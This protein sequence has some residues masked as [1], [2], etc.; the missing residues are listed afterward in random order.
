MWELPTRERT[1]GKELGTHLEMGRLWPGNWKTEG[2]T[3][4]RRLDHVR[5]AITRH[6]ILAEVFEG[7]GFD[8]RPKRGDVRDPDALF[9]TP[10]EATDRALTGMTR[11]I[12]ARNPIQALLGAPRSAG[13]TS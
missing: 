12:L 13:A 3:R 4:G 8:E 2:L 10:E 6:R 11:K 5:H 9:V 1:S 7:E